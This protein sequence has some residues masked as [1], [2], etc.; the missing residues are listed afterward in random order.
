MLLVAA[1]ASSLPWLV[2]TSFEHARDRPVAA[3]A[4]VVAA[5]IALQIATG[6]VA[7]QGVRGWTERFFVG[8][9]E[10]TAR[11]RAIERP[12][13]VLREYEQLAA[14]NQLGLFGPSKPPGTLAVYL[15]LERSSRLPLVRRVMQPWAEL[16]GRDPAVSPNDRTVYAWTLLVLGTCAALSALPLLLLG[17]VLFEDAEDPRVRTYPAWLFV[18]A[19]AINVVTVHLDSTVFPLLSAGALALCAWSA[20]VS[21]RS[22]R[23]ARSVALAAC[24]GVLALLAV[25]CSYGNLPVLGMVVLGTLAVG[26]QHGGR[27]RALAMPLIGLCAGVLAAWLVLVLWLEWQPI[28]GYLR[29]IAYH[30]AWRPNLPSQ[31]RHGLAFLEFSL[32]VGPPLILAFLVAT[33]LS[34]FRPLQQVWRRR[35]AQA[36]PVGPWAMA[37]GTS[38]LLLTLSLALGTPEAARLW[39]FTLPW[40]TCAASLC[41]VR[42]GLRTSL[43]MLLFVQVTLTFFVKNYLVW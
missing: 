13:E 14:A 10:Y 27:W 32:F 31:W 43:N 28:R 8:H 5:S 39:L 17:R 35:T 26:L 7:R 36:L 40:L 41:F 34:L 4:C 2:H 9:G 21:A 23:F 33:G 25:Y 15:A 11:A 37:L 30:R 38:A 22:A 18:S 6:L 3:A 42:R 29:G 1:A 16:V 12:L 20:R 19:P 24:G